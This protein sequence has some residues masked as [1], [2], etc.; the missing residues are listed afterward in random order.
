MADDIIVSGDPVQVY[1]NSV[2]GLAGVGCLGGFA[3]MMLNDGLNGSR[4]GNENIL[5]AIAGGAILGGIWA[6]IQI[7]TATPVT[8]ATD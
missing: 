1:I 6:N 5:W 2:L 8:N 4:K 3:W 7:Q